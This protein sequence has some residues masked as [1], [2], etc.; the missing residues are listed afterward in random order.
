MY[1]E[2]ESYV[3]SFCVLLATTWEL[4]FND[5]KF[6]FLRTVFV[7]VQLDA[8]LPINTETCNELF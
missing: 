3:T 6:F 2:E 1:F 8:V 4:K 5:T 7:V